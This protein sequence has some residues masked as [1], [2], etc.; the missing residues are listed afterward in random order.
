M[1]GVSHGHYSFNVHWCH[2]CHFR[3]RV[4]RVQEKS[5]AECDEWAG[6]QKDCRR[7]DALLSKLKKDRR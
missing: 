6:L 7:A 5:V 2:V 1:K 4:G 3:R